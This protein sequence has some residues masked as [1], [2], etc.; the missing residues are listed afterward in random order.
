MKGARKLPHDVQR[1]AS[2]E[3]LRTLKSPAVPKWRCDKRLLSLGPNLEIILLLAQPISTR[4]LQLRKKPTN[5][6]AP[7]EFLKQMSV[8]FDN[9]KIFLF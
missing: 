5:L 2:A 8:M 9:H 3:T 1:I 4:T 6:C 7:L